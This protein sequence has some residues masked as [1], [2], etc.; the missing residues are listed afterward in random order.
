MTNTNYQSI[1]RGNAER[2]LKT[3]FIFD[4]IPEKVDRLKKQKVTSLAKPSKGKPHIPPADDGKTRVPETSL[5]C[6]ALIETFM[7]KGIFCSIIQ[8]KDKDSISSLVGDLIYAIENVDL[9]IL[10][11]N[12]FRDDGATIIAV[13]KHLMEVRGYPEG[14]VS[15]ILIYTRE[16]IPGAMVRLQDEFA[17]L[18]PE[19]DKDNVLAM[20]GLRI[21]LVNRLSIVEE[22]LPDLIIDEFSEAHRGI[23]ENGVMQAISEIREKTYHVLNRFPAELDAPFLAHRAVLPDPVDSGR[24]AFELIS[25][26]IEALLIQ[27]DLPANIFQPGAITR[28]VDSIPEQKLI[29]ACRDG[30]QPN[31][32]K[33]RYEIREIIEGG[34]PDKDQQTY[35]IRNTILKAKKTKEKE[36]LSRLTD[37]LSLGDED[38]SDL[39][40]EFSEL[41]TF[42]HSYY[43]SP[44][45]LTLGTLICGPLNRKNPNYELCVLPYCDSERLEGK[46]SVPFLVLSIQDKPNKKFDMTISHNGV[47]IKL[48]LNYSPVKIIKHPFMPA[49]DSGGK[50]LSNGGIFNTAYSSDYKWIGTLKREFALRIANRLGSEIS[51]VGLNDSEWQ[52]LQSV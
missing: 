42:E 52:R 28:S 40:A 38:E 35:L 41:F 34:L 50:I 30:V 39:S 17:K 6:E 36:I 27:S 48:Y 44:K 32:P 1:Y 4:D 33:I 11:W 13:L 22:K 23:L 10:D 2:F 43:D 16:P 45:Q 12:L 9:P 24:H 5:D 8:P 14:R 21:V 7:Q 19:R 26:E 47:R 3:A 25:S 31:I 49:E 46:V 15:L 18:I 37:L 20:E 51:R 29:N